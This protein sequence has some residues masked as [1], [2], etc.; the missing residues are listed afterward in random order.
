MSDPTDWNQ[1][2][3]DNIIWHREERAL[4]A[5]RMGADPNHIDPSHNLHESYLHMAV[6]KLATE[7]PVHLL[8]VGANPNCQSTSGATPL[9]IAA[10]S[11]KAEHVETL[12]RHGAKPNLTT[13]TGN[14]ALHHGVSCKSQQVMEL[15]LRAGTD[16]RIANQ[17]GSTVDAL[18]RNQ[19]SDRTHR[20]L[21]AKRNLG[22]SIVPA[23]LPDALP[24]RGEVLDTQGD[25]GALNPLNIGFWQQF[26]HVAEKLRNE[27]K[28]LSRQDMLRPITADGR[29]H[30]LDFASHFFA[31]RKALRV[32]VQEGIGLTPQDLIDRNGLPRHFVLSMV[33][34]GTLGQLFT[35][36]MWKGMPP[37]Q[38]RACHHALQEM[39]PQECAQQIRGV[40]HLAALLSRESAKA[41]GV[42]R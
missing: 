10:L 8:L 1:V 22:N 33:Q 5:I 27:G 9:H 26:E 2:L 20:Y 21:Q 35:P 41:Q 34:S 17:N 4:E 12:L 3:L 6:R 29:E 31:E 16:M 28:P 30:L 7:L 19:S 11:G 25:S 32:L 37:S 38:L 14:T 23:A 36:E 42:G 13:D 18:A 40:H 15:L 24:E 39:F